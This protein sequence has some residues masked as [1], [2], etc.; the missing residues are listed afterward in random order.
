LSTKRRQ[1]DSGRLF[2]AALHAVPVIAGIGG[3]GECPDDVH[4]GEVPLFVDP[5]TTNLLLTENDHLSLR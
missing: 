5:D 1:L 4:D 3:V 2:L